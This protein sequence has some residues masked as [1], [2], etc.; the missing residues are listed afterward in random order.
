[1]NE[2]C[3]PCACG[4]QSACDQLYVPAFALPGAIAV[5]TIIVILLI[6][7][8]TGVIKIRFRVLISGWVIIALLFGWL[9]WF[10]TESEGDRTA[11]R[12]KL[13]QNSGNPGCEY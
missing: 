3:S 9:V 6:L 12:A 1:M 5:V 8:K 10:Q 11:K 7:A 4:V 13:C 2:G